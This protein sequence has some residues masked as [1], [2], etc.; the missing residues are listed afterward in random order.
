MKRLF[1]LLPLILLT[2]CNGGATTS[3]G[4]S[5]TSGSAPTSKS[6][7]ME[8]KFYLVYVGHNSSVYT[9]EGATFYINTS[10]S[11]L[12]FT[13]NGVQEYHPDGKLM[14]ESK[15]YYFYNN[16]YY[17]DTSLDTSGTNSYYYSKFFV[18][19]EDLIIGEPTSS[20]TS[21]YNCSQ[22]RFVTVS[23]AQSNNIEVRANNN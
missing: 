6:V 18:I 3:S 1:L 20:N 12:K 14:N 8:N 4:A 11:Y 23:Y 2:S 7:F 5:L 16:T 9:P 17:L 22:N 19:S 13:T 21:V 10:G 15:A